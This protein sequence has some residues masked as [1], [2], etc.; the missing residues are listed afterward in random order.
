VIVDGAHYFL[1]AQ[2]VWTKL[3]EFK[4]IGVTLVPNLWLVGSCG[5]KEIGAFFGY[6]Y[7]H[8]H[9]VGMT[10]AMLYVSTYQRARDLSER[11]KLKA[12]LREYNEDDVRSLPFILRAMERLSTIQHGCHSVSPRV[13]S[14]PPP[15][16]RLR[17]RSVWALP[18][19][20]SQ[21]SAKV[22]F[23]PAPGWLMR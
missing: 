11:R 16:L 18:S 20:L 14:P 10:V 3:Q 12:T 17:G 8:A 2:H 19:M 6:R 13:E 21:S 15:R 22:A 5:V 4:K 23:G 7:K 9:L 1:T